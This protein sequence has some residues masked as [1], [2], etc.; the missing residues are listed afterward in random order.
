MMY[1]QVG[2]PSNHGLYD[3][4]LQGWTALS[5]ESILSNAPTQAIL[6]CLSNML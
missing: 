3:W 4:I 2:H 1:L 6:R 5:S